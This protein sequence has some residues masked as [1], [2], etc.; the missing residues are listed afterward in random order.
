MATQDDMQNRQTQKDVAP[1][2]EEAA[3][4]ATRSAARDADETGAIALQT[5]SA[6]SSVQDELDGPKEANDAN[7]LTPKRVRRITPARMAAKL[8]KIRLTRPFTDPD[9]TVPVAPAVATS[10]ER[11]GR[12]ARKDRLQDWDKWSRFRLWRNTRPFWGSVFMFLGSLILL[13][14][15]VYFLQFAFIL[16]SLWASILIGALLLVMALAQLFVP[17]YSVLTGSVGIVLSLVSFTTSSFGGCLVGMLLGI[18]GGTL[19]LAWRP[20]K[21]SRLETARSTN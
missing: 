12:K 4:E 10:S 19:S 1:D 17:S 11:R 15:P 2:Q 7:R 16:N 13:G 14:P 20:V 21:R 18:I 8:H 6:S 3:A 5:A 9:Q